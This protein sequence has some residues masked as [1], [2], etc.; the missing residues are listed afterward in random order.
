MADKHWSNEKPDT[1]VG[2]IPYS[3]DVSLE[4]VMKCQQ[5]QTVEMWYDNDLIF[6]GGVYSESTDFWTNVFN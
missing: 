2:G 6:D 3:F 1:H 5:Q 4:D